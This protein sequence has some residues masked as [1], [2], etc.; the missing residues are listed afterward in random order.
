VLIGFGT[1]ATA[2][3]VALGKFASE[4]LDAVAVVCVLIVLAGAIAILV[5]GV[6]SMTPEPA[7]TADP[8]AL[9]LAL[10]G[11]ALASV[12]LFVN[13]DG[14]SSLWSEVGERESAEFF[15][16][17]AIAVVATLVG[18]VLLQARPRFAS[19]LLVAVGSATV[20]HFAGVLVAAWRAIG[21]V[22]EV[23]SAGVV[24]VLGGLIV[25]AAGAYTGRVT[26]SR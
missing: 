3:A 10:V 8:G 5:A 20:L 19:G 4:R 6:R 26:M 9:V 23:G 21:E 24:G 14:L 1:L 2:G 15:F 13:Y 7:V 18:I 25:L 22:G 16:E 11:A 17:P 12:A